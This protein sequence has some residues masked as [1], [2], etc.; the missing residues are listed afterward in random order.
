RDSPT[1]L[2]AAVASA[3]AHLELTPSPD[4]SVRTIVWVQRARS[5]FAN[6]NAFSQPAAAEHKTA[7]HAQTMWERHVGAETTATVFASFTARDRAPDVLAAPAIVVERLR[8]GPVPSLLNP[9]T[10]SDASWSA[11]GSVLLPSATMLGAGHSARIGV[12]VSG[13]RASTRAG[14]SG[15][16]G[17]L[18]DGAPARVWDYADQGQQS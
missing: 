17:E 14:F 3:F 8:D 10:G 7:I 5:P 6:R 16:I 9:R 2:D 12:E 18:V 1:R 11:G 13:S 15:R 4:D